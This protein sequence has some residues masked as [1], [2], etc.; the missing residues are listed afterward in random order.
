MAHYRFPVFFEARDLTDSEKEKIQKYFKIRRKSGG[1]ECG[2]VEKVDDDTYKILFLEQE[3]QERVLG[4]KTHVIRLTSD[5]HLKIKTKQY[6]MNEIKIKQVSQNQQDTPGKDEE[7]VLV[8]ETYLTQYLQDSP[9][10]RRDLDQ[11]LSSL[12]RS[13]RILPE[14]GKVVVKRGAAHS[15]LPQA[16]W[17]TQVDN[18]CFQLK[19]RYRCYFE[20]DPARVK[21]LQENPFM[22]SENLCTYKELR[23]DLAV[24]VG[25]HDAIEKMIQRLD[26]LQVKPQI[27]RD[28]GIPL[29][30]FTLVEEEFGKKIKVSSPH[31]KITMQG[32]GRPVFEGPEAEV[33]AA[34]TT[35][36]ELVKKIQQR[37]LQLPAP[38]LAFLT[39]SG[40]METYQTRFQQSLRS[41]VMLEV[42]PDLVLSSLTTEALEEAAAALERDLT[43][44]TVVLERAETES[45]G[46]V[47]LKEVLSQALQQANH[48]TMKVQLSYGKPSKADYR[49]LVQIVGN[50]KEV[51]RLKDILLDHKINQTNIHYSLNLPN[52]VVA[53]H[54]HRVLELLGVQHS[55]LQLIPT[56]S[57]S[58]CL[59]FAGPRQLVQEFYVTLTSTLQS[60]VCKEYSME[61]PGVLQYFNGE[62]KN[63]IAL[64]ELS[65]KVLIL[66]SDEEKQSGT[67]SQPTSPISIS[68]LTMMGKTGP[69]P[70][71]IPSLPTKVTGGSSSTAP[72]GSFLTGKKIKLEVVLG[73]LEDQQVDVLVAPMVKANLLSLKIG[74]ALAKT[75]GDQLKRNFSQS[76][77][78]QKN[79]EPGDIFQVEGTSTLGCQKIIFVECLPWNA[80]SGSSE[81]ALRCG[82]RQALSL[83]EQCALNSVAFP[84][85]GPGVVLK[86]PVKEAVSILTSEIGL[87]GLSGLTGSLSN[88]RIVIHPDYPDSKAV[89]RDVY[90]GLNLHRRDGKGQAVFGSLTSDLEEVTLTVGGIQLYLVRGDITNETTDAIVNT[91]DFN[92]FDSAVCKSIL[93]VAGPKVKKALKSAQVNRGKIFTSQPGKFP[94][95]AIMHVCGENDPELVQDL[96]RDILLH[97]ESK[98]Y[99]SVAIP[100]ICAAAGVDP[101]IVA[102]AIFSGIVAAVSSCSFQH[103]VT[104]RLVLFS[105]PV[106]QQFQAAADAMFWTPIRLKTTTPLRAST[107][108]AQ[109]TQPGSLYPDLS[110]LLP[111]S[112]I[113]AVP[114]SATF[115]ILGTSVQDVSSVCAGLQ[116]AYTSHCSQQTLA[117]EELAGLSHAELQDLVGRVNSL[118]VQL[119]PSGPGSG[120]GVVVRGLNEGVNEVM[121]VMQGALRR[122]VVERDQRELFN[123][124]VWCIMGQRGDWERFPKEANQK[125]EKGVTGGVMDA[126]GCCWNVDLRRK[127]ATAVGSGYVTLVKRL[128]NLPDFKV[129]LYWD[130][131]VPGEALQVIPL[132]PLCAEFERVKADFR[133]C[134]RTIL[135]IERV[136]NV[137]LRR[138]F[139]V[140][141]QQLED[142]NGAPV[143]AGEKMLY[144]GTTT[145]AC[146]S[147]MK[148][149][150]NRGFAGQNATVYGLGT[151]FAVSASY[152]AKPV[153]SRPEADGTQCMFVARVLAGFYTL[154]KSL[155]RVPPP[156]SPQQPDIRFDSLVDNQQNPSMFVVFHDSQAYPDYLITFK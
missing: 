102:D 55:D 91:T 128:Q 145:Q 112:L 98:G 131:L 62:G 134:M 141:R 146:Q 47:T 156:V 135:K 30:Q 32:R 93:S 29:M 71:P 38:L 2:P 73:H 15:G 22:C 78:F 75:G 37:I 66:L 133:T 87:F 76:I 39:S 119:E 54:L 3:D 59:H 36:Q 100:A 45:P 56:K 49:M 25:E 67:G 86:T 9:K 115:I 88:I 24:V 81:K 99:Q 57:P 113:P 92:N 142:K 12:C 1:G 104:V 31:I 116:Q 79:V 11:C 89:C 132:I 118:G 51:D 27:H 148:T 10:A 140:Q 103:L 4:P 138:A 149:G 48:G 21:T 105:M 7:K 110:S 46:M 23:E 109:T 53:D 6:A 111:S 139:D 77:R 63:N 52:A 72:G 94:C 28:C 35:L 14:E 69:T 17:E 83:C 154:G 65:H 40:A 60:L 85:I 126:H 44:E 84:L 155:M 117:P 68:N 16:K 95:K 97:C 125:L 151:Y 120:A 61:G 33:E 80:T 90:G 64:L 13:F 74:Q 152:S 150:F 8:M 144:H 136:Q 114:P 34:C 58:P 122:Q 82:M 96:T 18:V 153:Y 107:A 137:H 124:V 42:G 19:Q 43:V 26:A 121:Y 101:C 20:V 127:Q 147:I 5:Q 108:P 106:F 130:S 41:P 129:P 123:N 50:R 143:G 70:A